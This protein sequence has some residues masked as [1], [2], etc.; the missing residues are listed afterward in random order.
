MNVIAYIVVAVAGDNSDITTR[1]LYEYG[2]IRDGDTEFL[3]V[4]SSM[5]LHSSLQHLLSNM[6]TLFFLGFLCEFLLGKF[7]YAVSYIGCGILGGISVIYFSPENTVTTGASGAISGLVG[8]LIVYGIGVKD[9]VLVK[10]MMPVIIFDM[11]F[12]I[13]ALIEDSNISV[14]GH[15]GGLVGGAVIGF[16]LY[17]R[18]EK[19]TDEER[20][21]YSL[22]HPKTGLAVTFTLFIGLVTGGFMASSVHSH[23]EMNE[24]RSFTEEIIEEQYSY[25]ELLEEETYYSV[26]YDIELNRKLKE[27][28]IP[29]LNNLL[30]KLETKKIENEKLSAANETLI[31]SCKSCI[32]S[33]E[34]LSLL[35]ETKNQ[36]HFENY[37]NCISTFSDKIDVFYGEMREI[38]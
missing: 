18:Q 26:V 6:L 3:R 12:N 5:F 36:T 30:N 37:K 35:Y 2:G 19:K 9:K 16:I 8:V 38:W 7:F 33:F 22:T 20:V 1:T 11:I 17:I 32:K 23:K 10:A 25:Y 31:F 29:K 34:E 13:V 14:S 27:E 15:M 4:F 21:V 28:V 24:Y